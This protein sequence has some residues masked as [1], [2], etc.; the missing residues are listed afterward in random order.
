MLFFRGFILNQQKEHGC[1][2]ET[3]PGIFKVALNL[4][5]RLAFKWQSLEIL[6]VFNSLTFKQIFWKT[7]PFSKNW[8]ISFYL[9]VLRL[10]KKYF[11]AKLPCQKPILGQIELRKQSEPLT[12]SGVLPRNTSFLKNFIWFNNFL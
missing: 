3:V 9:K 12:K 5:D 8:K 4:G 11:H 1:F 10:K 2:H 6:N 7:K